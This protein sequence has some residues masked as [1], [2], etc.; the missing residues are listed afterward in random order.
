MKSL[1]LT[2]KELWAENHEMA[3][4][5]LQLTNEEIEFAK[6]K[7]AKV[8]ITQIR[9]DNL[10]GCKNVDNKKMYRYV[11]ANRNGRPRI[12]KGFII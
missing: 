7:L 5:H 4:F 3:T 11:V 12:E 9:L 10:S 8:G 1:E 2:E 6:E